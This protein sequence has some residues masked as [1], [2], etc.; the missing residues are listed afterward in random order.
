M[1]FLTLIVDGQ[2]RVCHYLLVLIQGGR[3]RGYHWLNYKGAP[4]DGSSWPAEL[5]FN[6]YWTVYMVKKQGSAC[7]SPHGQHVAGVGARHVNQPARKRMLIHAHARHVNQPARKRVLIHAHARTA[8]PTGTQANV[9]TRT[10]TTCQ[11]PD[12]KQFTTGN[13]PLVLGL[14]VVSFPFCHLCHLFL[15]RKLRFELLDLSPKS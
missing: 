9:N 4:V 6:G 2:R 15:C 12:T 7:V 11:S 14:P 13:T 1:L 8:Q 3:R 10:C 5:D